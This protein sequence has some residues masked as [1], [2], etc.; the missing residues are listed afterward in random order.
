[1]HFYGRVA[2]VA[3]FSEFLSAL[4]R[5]LRGRAHAVLLCPHMPL[6]ALPLITRARAWSRMVCLGDYNCYDVSLL[7]MRTLFTSVKSEVDGRRSAAKAIFSVF[8]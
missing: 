4:L 7:L 8:F 2:A 6:A 5:P 1:M 3:N